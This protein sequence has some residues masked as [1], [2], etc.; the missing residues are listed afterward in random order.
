MWRYEAIDLRTPGQPVRRVGEIAGETAAEARAALRSVGLQVLE[1]RPDRDSRQK[2]R[3]KQA[4]RLE[5]RGH[6]ALEGILRGRRVQERADAFDALATLLASGVPLVEA[7]ETLAATHE[8]HSRPLRRVLLQVR[9]ELRAG[10]SLSEAL[11]PHTGWFD[12]SEVAM[13]EAAQVAGTL[14]PTLAEIASRQ[15]RSAAVAQ[16]LAGALAYPAIVSVVGVAVALFLA[17]RTLPQLTAILTSARLETPPLTSALMTVGAVVTDWWPTFLLAFVGICIGSV[18][19]GPRALRSAGPAW[20][21]RIDLMV[22]LAIRR[23]AV[24]RMLLRIADLLRAGVPLVE[25]LRTVGPGCSGL[26]AGLGIVVMGAAQR[27]EE[28]EDFSAALSGPQTEAWFDAES[29]RLIAVGEAG[30]ELAPILQRLGERYERQTARLVDRLA[31]LLEPAAVILLAILVGTVVMA[32]VLPLLK[33][34]EIL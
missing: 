1:I 17:T 33:L 24:S 11:T 19:L 32:A 13:V 18:L 29:R 25:S 27:L 4:P 2:P 3:T 6:R 14:A 31:A 30:G 8:G 9:E 28:G 12:P 23:M 5:Q 26:S 21:R 16:K 34:Q 15:A 22:P 20:R 10:K 7:M